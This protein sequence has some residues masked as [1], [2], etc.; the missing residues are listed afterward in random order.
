[1]APDDIGPLVNW[2]GEFL[3]SDE[4]A[5]VLKKLGSSGRDQ[6]H[7][8]LFVPSFSTVAYPVMD[9]LW[10][11]DVGLV[12]EVPRLPPEV[13]HVWAF[14]SWSDGRVVHW[15]PRQGWELFDK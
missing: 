13:T 10:R 9:V 4:Q 8:V 11:N 15:G 12:E 5:D 7:A 2:V 14:S 3:G 1:M 6:R